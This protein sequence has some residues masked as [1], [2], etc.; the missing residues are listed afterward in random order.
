MS[1]ENIIEAV[2]AIYERAGVTRPVKGL[3]CLRHTFGTEMARRV[4]LP[5]L[6]ELM[7]HADVKTTLRY[8]DVGESDKRAAIARVYGGAAA[9]RQP[10]SEL[11][12]DVP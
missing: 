7:G 4:P 2:H 3:H 10:E 5:V 9:V 11:S 1:Y 6:K 12:G 8:I